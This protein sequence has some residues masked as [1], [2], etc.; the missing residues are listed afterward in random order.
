MIRTRVMVTKAQLADDGMVR[1]TLTGLQDSMAPDAGPKSEHWENLVIKVTVDSE[2]SQ[3]APVGTQLEVR[4][5][6]LE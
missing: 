2:F 5:K 1:L 3:K 6:H 4:L